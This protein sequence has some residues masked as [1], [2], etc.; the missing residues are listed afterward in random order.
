[1]KLVQDDR[2]SLTFDD[3]LLITQGSE[4][5]SRSSIDISTSLGPVMPNPWSLSPKIS[6]LIASPM[7]TVSESSMANAMAS[8]NAL[9]IIHRYL[10]I[11]DQVKEVRKSNPQKNIV[12]AAVGATRDF[13]ERAEALLEA[14]ASVICVDV[15]HGHHIHVRAALGKLQ[16][17]RPKHTFHLMAGNVGSG[18]GFI[19]LSD[20]GADSIRLGIGSGSICSTRLNTGHGTPTFGALVNCVESWQAKYNVDWNTDP[21]RPALIVDGG[22][23]HP[24]DIVKALAAGADAVIC[25]SLFAG[26][27]E[28]PGEVIDL[29]NQKAK[30]Y[31][32]MASRESQNQWRGFSN[33]PEGIA[34]MIPFKGSVLPIL[35][36]LIGNIIGGLSYSGAYNVKELMEKAI[37]VR[38][39]PASQQESYTHILNRSIK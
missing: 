22:I 34:T 11:E 27:E 16:T 3:V 7:D 4:I 10:S 26:T 25:G 30:A 21:R 9:A 20:W 36:D 15:A 14:G 24:G 39:T 38:Q 32:G 31:R 1:M 13:F 6:P 29:G 12:G 18:D 19:A 8:K 33:A 28:S 2:L 37:F 17:L 5:T 23:K 35:D